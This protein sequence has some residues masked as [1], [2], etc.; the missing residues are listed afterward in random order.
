MVVAAPSSEAP[1]ARPGVSDPTW[2]EPPP[3]DGPPIGGAPVTG[4]KPP[5]KGGA[6]SAKPAFDL[7]E[8]AQKS[9]EF[10]RSGP[11]VAYYGYRW[12]DPVTGRWP[13]G[14][15]IGE[16]GGIILYGFVGNDGVG[17]WD[18]LGLT[19]SIDCIRCS[20]DP[21]GPLSCVLTRA[22]GSTSRF[23]TNDPG[24]T[25][26]LGRVNGP[27]DVNRN[28]TVDPDEQNL[29]YNFP[30]HNSSD[31]YGSYGPIA[32]G[33][34]IISPRN[35]A[36]SN[37]VYPNGTPTI[38]TPGYRNGTIIGGE[39]NTGQTNRGSVFFHGC[40]WSDGCMT[41]PQQ[42]LNTINNEMENGDIPMNIREVCCDDGQLPPAATPVDSG[43]RN[44]GIGNF[45]NRLLNLFR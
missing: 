33:S 45:F 11:S 41:T 21:N 8:P 13:S 38:N 2:P 35:N 19:A 27:I 4:P 12:L 9:P 22:D 36:N 7:S 18:V 30:R 29:P 43:T 26:H 15:P 23:N 32:P 37:S 3:D 10:Q 14:D 1:A 16:R 20:D 25:T 28:G 34:Y 40:G 39:G 24:N 31:P 17:K 44:S 5:P 6:P 42:N